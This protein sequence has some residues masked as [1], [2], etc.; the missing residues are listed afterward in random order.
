MAHGKPHVLVLG[1]NFAGLG[2]AQK[3]REMAGDAVDITLVDRKPYL[4][5]IPNIPA[6]VFANRNPMATMR[7]DIVGPLDEDN[8]RFVEAEITAIDPE[9]RRVECVPSERPG[10]ESLTLGYDFLVVALGNRLAF[11]RIEGFA[12]HG[13]TVTDTWHGDKLR[14]YLHEDY[15][16]G[17]I[18][19]GSAR[20]HQGDGTNEVRLYKGQK[21]PVATAA[22]EGPPV[23]MMMSLGT[24][25]TGL[26]RGGP[27]TVTVFTPADMIAE[28]AGEQVVH[29]LLEMASQLGFHY[30]HSTQ[31]ISRITAGGIE[32]ANGQSLDAELKIIFPDWRA[33]DFLRS[34]PVTDSEGFVVTDLTMRNPKYPNVF[35]AGDA[36]AITVPKLGAIGHDE[37]AIVGRQIAKDVGRMKAK[38]A[39]QPLQPEILCIGDMGQNKAF[40]IHSNTW[41]GGDIS[42]L[43]LGRVEYALKNQYKNLFYRNGGKIPPWGIDAAKKIAETV[44]L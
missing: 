22:C 36:A 42:E 37:A 25:L 17:P 11:D 7:M 44:P 2:C 33:H 5:Y 40:Y 32:F 26:G 35:A 41:F 21:F 4:A 18:A 13:H 24:W 10:G 12:A 28:D 1:G 31:D 34:L 27:S 19:V 38:E 8:I 23:E 20:F 9:T 30:M 15:K 6:E 39:D 43:H 14:R 29:Q 3:I 16:G